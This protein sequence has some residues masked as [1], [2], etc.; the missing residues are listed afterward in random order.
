MTACVADTEARDQI[1]TR[2]KQAIA[3]FADDE[4]TTDRVIPVVVLERR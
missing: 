1:G 4:A 2:Q 3:T